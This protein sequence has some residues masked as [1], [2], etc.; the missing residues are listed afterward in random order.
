MD[1]KNPLRLTGAATA[2]RGVLSTVFV[3]LRQGGGVSIGA[4]VFLCEVSMCLSKEAEML[5]RK[6]GELS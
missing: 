5:E 3:V 6:L 1:V 4:R 2:C